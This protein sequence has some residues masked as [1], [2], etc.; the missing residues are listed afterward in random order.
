MT[1]AEYQRNLRAK[2]AA[3]GRC[4]GCRANPPREGLSTCVRCGD[5]DSRRSAVNHEWCEHCQASDGHRFDCGAVK[6]EKRGP[7]P[8]GPTTGPSVG[9]LIAAMRRTA[10]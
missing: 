2:A 6:R 5:R 4:S 1:S 10:G 9:E 3:N 8:F 7:G